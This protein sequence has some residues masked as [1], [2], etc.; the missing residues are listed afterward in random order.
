[1]LAQIFKESYIYKAV[2]VLMCKSSHSLSYSWVIYFFINEDLVNN[3]MLGIFL[4]P[5]ESMMQKKGKLLPSCSK[6]SLLW[7]VV[8]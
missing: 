4:F 3:N 7:R 5:G 1:M 6:F 8:L 2:N